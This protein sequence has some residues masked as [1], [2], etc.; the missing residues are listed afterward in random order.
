MKTLALLV[1]LLAATPLALA[2]EE[3]APDVLVRK[4]TDEVLES[5]R[6]DKALQ[7]G[8]R[9]RAV[10]LAEEK[11][12]PLIDFRQMTRLAAGMLWRD[13]TEAQR[14]RLTAEFRAMLIR[15]YS[16][17]IDVYRGQT[18]RVLPTR[19]RPDSSEATVRNQYLRPGK[20]PVSIDYRMAR[21]PSGWKIID[22][23][24][25]GISLALTYRTE[26]NEEV[27]RSGIDGLLQRMHDKN[28]GR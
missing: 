28:A 24:V 12:L 26:F 13:A 23:T 27:R 20:P 21:T 1:S 19:L 9:D 3:L 8:D 25:E 10:A 2:Q 18:M 14:E 16:K 7:A 17:A 5:I 15:T 11:V 4:M 22:I 6:R